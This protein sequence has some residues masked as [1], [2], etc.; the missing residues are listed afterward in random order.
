VDDLPGRPPDAE[1]VATARAGG[2]RDA[3]ARL[4]RRHWPAAVALAARVLG[5]PD[6]ATDAAQEGAIA[7]LV[8]LDRLREPDRFG[9]WYCGITLNVARRWAR[10]L[11]AERPAAAPDRA[12]DQ[13]G[14]AE[15]AELAELAAAVRAAVAQLPD[16]QRRA[17][18]LFYLRGLTHR[19]VAAELAI[20][21]GAVKARLHQA[22]ASLTPALTPLITTP[23]ENVMMTTAGS[24]AWAEVAV[25]EIR[26]SDD[27]DPLRRKHVMVLAEPAGPG[28]L[29]IW[30]GPAEAYS[31]ALSLESQEAPRPLTYQFAAG[32]LAAATASVS[33]VRITRLTG[34]IFYAVV[35]VD[36]P[37]GRQEVDARP[38]DAVNLALVTGAR[39]LADPALLADPRVTAEPRWQE[40]RP[41]TAELAAEAQQRMSA[42]GQSPP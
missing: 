27:D 33:E 31:L 10:Q 39:I 20:S 36:G 23:E 2:G 22:R 37:G 41:S 11:R 21:V 14:P 32:L 4:V 6:L 5:S 42:M 28:R 13:P 34:Q 7:A 35:V 26:R 9:A 19:E 38:S 30:I 17:V 8:S 3:F 1:L 29:P 16:G 18:F 25:T 12:S 24:Q 15:Q 40:L